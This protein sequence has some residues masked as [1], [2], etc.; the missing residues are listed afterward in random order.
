MSVMPAI[1]KK[2]MARRR[3]EKQP[4][5]G[6]KT[7]KKIN[8]GAG[9]KTAADFRQSCKAIGCIISNEADDILYKAMLTA[10]LVKGKVELI[11]VQAEELGFAKDSSATP[12]Q[13]C[14][15]AVERGLKLC[16]AETAIRLRLQY[17]DQKRP[18]HCCIGM[19]TIS[20][21][22][23]EKRMFVVEHN[24]TN[25]KRLSTINADDPNWNRTILWVFLR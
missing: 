25:G 1:E 17:A 8:L 4:A 22:R 14:C 3:E 10:S 2:K 5:H 12:G 24:G 15:R 6:F 18:E 16:S 13:V 11:A 20:D 19:E 21:S 9:P 7:W 23:K